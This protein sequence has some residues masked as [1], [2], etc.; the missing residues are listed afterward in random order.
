MKNLSMIDRELE[1]KIESKQKDLAE[2]ISDKAKDLQRIKL[3][4]RF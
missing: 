2:K 4:K 1:Q 3:K